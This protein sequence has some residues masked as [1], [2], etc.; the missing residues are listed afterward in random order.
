MSTILKRSNYFQ[1]N[2]D[3]A[4][5]IIINTCA[6]KEPTENKIKA[7]LKDLYD[8]YRFEPNKH[9]VI[10]GCLPHITP[11]YINVI[12]KIVPNF[13]AI[14]DLDNINEITEVFGKIK[15]GKK[16]L[17]IST[18]KSIDK[19]EFLLDYPPEKI[20]GIISI[21]EG[22][23]GSCTYCC[24][25]NARGK[26]NCYNPQKIVE[27]VKHQLKQGIKQVYLTSQDCSIYQRNETKLVDL[28]QNIV[29]LDFKFFLRI[30][31]INPSFL[32]NNLDQ[33]TTI[34]KFE[35]VYQ[36]LHIPIQSGSNKILERMQRLYLISD[37][38]DQIEILR[39]MFPKLTIST[40]I[41]CGFPGETEYDFYR[42]VNFIKWL[43][44]E[45]MNV[46]KFGP[47]PHTKAKN[48]TQ[49]DGKIIKERSIR[50]SRV[51]RNSLVNINKKWEDWEGEVLVLHEGLKKNQAFGRNFAYKNVFIDNYMDVFGK[52]V[53][54]K[55]ER[56]NGPNLFGKII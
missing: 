54:I 10:T 27:N 35:K 22:C 11:K 39:D 48:M 46:S 24:V 28:I 15:Q 14:I 17:I 41:I 34:F 31:M 6:V 7:R 36:F 18:N 25:K 29:S 47:R 3:K 40:D 26:L 42:S 8:L 38:I 44:P 4:L 56:V 1:T 50:M 16:N 9:I 55:I 20:T 43:K 52:F 21:S 23:L 30:G 13:S 19:A 33:L 49:L 2:I 37:V 51:F 45:I 53:K 32:I 12:K 5:F